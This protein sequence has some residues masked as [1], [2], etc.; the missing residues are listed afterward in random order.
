MKILLAVSVLT[1]SACVGNNSQNFSSSFDK[2][3]QAEDMAIL[4]ADKEVGIKCAQ[5]KPREQ[6]TRKQAVKFNTCA[7]EI[8]E[9]KV[10]PVAAYPALFVKFRA[11]T[12]ENAQAYQDGKISFAQ[13]RARNKIAWVSYLEAQDNKANQTLRHLNTVDAM[14][15]AELRDAMASMPKTTYTTCNTSTH[16]GGGTTSCTTR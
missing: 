13:Q 1:L 9:A 10:L 8:F 2:S 14:E 7:T 11:E 3:I 15:R 6:I 4:E 16:F 5:G 12:L